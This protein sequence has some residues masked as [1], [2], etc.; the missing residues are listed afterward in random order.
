MQFFTKDLTPDLWNDFKSYFEFQGSNS[1]CW[2]MNHRMPLGLD[3]DGEAAKLAIKQ[4]IENK[5]VYGVLAYTTDD[6]IP[7]GWCSLDPRKSLP[8][9]DCIG[10]DIKNDQ[11]VWSI[12]CV[13]V[14]SD[15]KN[16]GVERALI[17]ASE[18]LANKLNA[19][20]LEVYPEP[21]SKE[22]SPFKTWNT[23]NGY[24]SI[25]YELGFKSKNK[26]NEFYHTMKKMLT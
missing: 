9:H 13:T 10:Y 3:F 22:D 15:F 1:G 18:A 7:I 2:C 17:L 11:N 24:E 25:F 4:L 6:S 23:F 19:K 21:K 5:K 20:F 16:K 26:I 14:R 12:H 8:G